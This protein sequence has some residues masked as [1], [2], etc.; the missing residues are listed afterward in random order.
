MVLF[1]FFLLPQNP[2]LT[3]MLAEAFS[4]VY[5]PQKMAVS[6]FERKCTPHSC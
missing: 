5:S 1:H 6:S 3:V 2:D 4:A